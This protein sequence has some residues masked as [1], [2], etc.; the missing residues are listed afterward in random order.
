MEITECE[1]T[2]HTIQE[3]I[4]MLVENEAVL[5]SSARSRARLSEWLGELVSGREAIDN[6]R[7]ALAGHHNTP[8]TF[9]Y[10]P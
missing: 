4:A 10:D 6:V 8:V 1:A 9:G 2:S 3:I 5:F 7:I